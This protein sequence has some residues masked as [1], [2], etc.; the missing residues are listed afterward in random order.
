MAHHRPC[1]R[2]RGA[3]RLPRLAER[4]RRGRQPGRQQPGRRSGPKRV[5]TWN[6]LRFRSQSEARIAV[7]LDRAGLRFF[8]NCLAR[9]KI[10]AD[11]TGNREPD[12]L[13]CHYGKLGVLQVDGEM[14]HPP[15]RAA[16]DHDRDRLFLRAGVKLVQHYD[17]G[18]V[19]RRR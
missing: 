13:I 4:T 3:G 19:L 16:Q 9:L 12:F 6:N 17:A 18:G 5:I 8:P 2:C 15:S 14:W 10:A 1:R 11:K 7:A